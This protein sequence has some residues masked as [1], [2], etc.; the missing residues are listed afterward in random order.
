MK[1][2]Y[3]F[4]VLIVCLVAFGNCNKKPSKGYKFNTPVGYK[5]VDTNTDGKIDTKGYF[6][7][8]EGNYRLFYNE[9]DRN[10]DGFTDMMLWVGSSSAP[11]KE[12]IVKDVVKVHEEEDEDYDGK[13]D[14][15]KWYLPNEFIALSQHDKD[16]D[17]YFEATTYYN[18]K[19]LP[20]RTEV[21]T[22]FDGRA[23]RIIWENRAEL[24][25]DFDGIP[26]SYIEAPTRLILE[27]SIERK[28]GIKPLEKAKSWFLN[29]TLA[30]VDYRAIIGSGYF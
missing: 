7:D 24:D 21:D 25:T 26:D 5:E 20:V 3:F 9:L 13:V 1:R 16:K 12:A 10:L 22:N 14:V 17:G 15:L 30:P 4:L 29:P 27:D 19:K 28:A 2:I 6:M 18:F 23:D 11:K 8:D